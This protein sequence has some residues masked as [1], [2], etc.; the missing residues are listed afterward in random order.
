[1]SVKR[2]SV[3]INKAP[4]PV[5]YARE[6]LRRQKAASTR[7]R[8]S[9][10]RKVF[11]GFVLVLLLVL[12]WL[13]RYEGLQIKEVK[14][15]GHKTVE[16]SEVQKIVQ[17]DLEGNYF[18]IFPRRNFLIYPREK[19]TRDILRSSGYIGY[20]DLKVKS[21]ATL[22]VKIA[23]RQAKYIWCG[24]SASTSSC[25]LADQTGLLFSP[26]P[27]ISKN[28][29]F[30]IY[31]PLPADAVGKAPLARAGFAR[32]DETIGSLPAVL[33]F[34]GLKRSDVGSVRVSGDNDYF[35]MIEN[36]ADRGSEEWELRFKAESK[37]SSVAS[38][39]KAL[40]QSAEFQ[41]ERSARALDYVDL[42]FGK[43]VYY[44]FDSN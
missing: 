40:W 24:D 41:A 22:E 38:Y 2:S 9:L 43:K 32:L 6:D 7:R 12:G 14:V 26:A 36:I 19:I 1:M 39:L 21:V 42:R 17:A 20:V 10:R 3:P 5:V 31:S 23:E 16:A 28:V 34:S 4:R 25:Y 11:L 13:M 15:L 44:K 33:D 35:F 18:Y 30:V 37:L 29:M 27:G 8:R